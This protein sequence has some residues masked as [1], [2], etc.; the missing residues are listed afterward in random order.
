MRPVLSA[1][2]QQGDDLKTQAVIR[3]L[4]ATELAVPDADRLVMLPS[5]NQPTFDNRVAWAIQHMVRAGLI[6]RPQ[7]GRYK[8]SDRGR[9]VLKDHPDRVDMS[10]LSNFP[11]Y[12]D[13]RYG[14]SHTKASTETAPAT[15]MSDELSP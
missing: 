7:R 3:E 5:G 10:E 12:I 9:T 13:F 11:E 14:G 4:V 15:A 2:Q 6:D 8:L 1:L